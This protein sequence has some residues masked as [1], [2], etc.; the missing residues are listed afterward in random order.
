MANQMSA[1]D[2]YDAKPLVSIEEI[3]KFQARRRWAKVAWVYSALLLVTTVMLGTFVVAFLASLK[4]NPLEQP[5]TFSF[6]QVQ[7]SNWHA[8]YQLGKEGNDAPFFG[9]F[10]PGAEVNFSVTYAA[11][12]GKTLATP[13][14]EV[15]RRRPGTGMAA[16]IVKDFASDYAVVSEPI[17]VNTKDNVTFVE[18]RG[19][20]E[21]SKKGHSQTWNFTIRY[22]GDG[23]EVATLPLTV[24]VPRG[25]VLIDSTLSP[26][27][28]ERRGRVA[29]W[30]NAAPGMI[31]YV[32]KSYVRVYTESVSLETGNSLFMSW[33]INSFFIAIGKVLLTL[34]FA[35]TAGYALAR[36][37]FTGARAVF[38]FMLFSMMIPGQVT[39]IS[40][41]L[42]YKD[43]G[44]LNTPWAVI[45]AWWLRVRF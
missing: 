25:Q 39:F 28:M 23:P 11:E 34:F 24:E 32:F 30:D 41:Y 4:D 17:L 7:P 15:P 43:I 33:T 31:G 14:I 18:K 21:I 8:A 37:K 42:I 26:S 1:T 35:C 29:A 44:L 20:R 16:A 19:R 22:H 40:N 27:K 13:V 10:G 5:F 36:L 2:Q 38:A 3:S 12:E 6:A 45:T 9:G